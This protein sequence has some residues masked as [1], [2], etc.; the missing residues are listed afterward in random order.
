MRDWKPYI[1]Y[2]DKFLD[3]ISWFMRVGGISL[4]PFVILRERYLGKDPL[5]NKYT[6]RFWK[7]KAKRIINHETIHFQ[8]QLE[9]LIIPFYIIY[10]ME[11]II[12]SLLLFSIKKG[13]MA[14]SFEREAY[15]N[16][17]NLEYLKTRKRYSWIKRIFK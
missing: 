1:K 4:F 10:V 14:I 17:D 15:D 13:Y 7:D 8:Q 11:Y 9:L 6:N 16:D 5:V 2:N 12:K 3:A